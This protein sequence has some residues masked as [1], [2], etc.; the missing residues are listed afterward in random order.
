MS[1]INY[2]CEQCEFE[3]PASQ[4]QFM[5]FLCEECFTES[6]LVRKRAKAIKQS[7]SEFEEFDRGYTK[8][9]RAADTSLEK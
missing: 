3:V 2:L 9:L 8:K 5:R 7:D 6:A 4:F 1:I